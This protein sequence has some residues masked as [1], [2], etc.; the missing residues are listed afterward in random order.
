MTVAQIQTAP[1]F[2]VGESHRL[3]DASGFI[4]LGFH[5]SYDVTADGRSFLLIAPKR[6]GPSGRSPTIVQAENWFADV[7]SRLRQ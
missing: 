1:S 3:F 5:Q 7:R 4:D 2:A 6:A